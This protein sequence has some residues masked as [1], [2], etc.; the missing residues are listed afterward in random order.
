VV[1]KLSKTGKLTV[2]HKFSPGAGGRYPAPTL[3]HDPSGAL[4]GTTGKGG[5]PTAC[6]P[7]PSGPFGP[8][9]LDAGNAFSINRPPSGGP[10]CGT[11]FKLTP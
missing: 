5:S 10:G 1:F 9:L 6:P 7:P 8:P 2:L 11:V 4:Y 3:V